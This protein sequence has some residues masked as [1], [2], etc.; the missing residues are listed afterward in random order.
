MKVEDIYKKS[1]IRKVKKIKHLRLFYLFNFPI[2]LWQ[3]DDWDL[4]KKAK[5]EIINSQK[6][7]E[8]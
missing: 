5:L 2:E 1:F 6:T 4:W 8:N 7:N 3:K